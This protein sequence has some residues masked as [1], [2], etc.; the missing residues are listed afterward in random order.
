M[1]RLGSRIVLVSLLLGCGCTSQDVH[2]P[3][4][5]LRFTSRAQGLWADAPI[6]TREWDG[7][8]RVSVVVHNPGPQ[9]AGLLAQIDWYD[10]YGRPV[11]TVIRGSARISVPREG[12]VTFEHVNA[13]P[14]ATDFRIVIDGDTPYP[15]APVPTR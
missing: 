1:R 3:E 13:N 8:S 2:P 6:F 9:D 14:G 7:M 10:A 11:P 5:R 4:P 15:P 12:E